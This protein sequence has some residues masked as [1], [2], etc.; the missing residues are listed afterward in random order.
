MCTGNVEIIRRNNSYNINF[1]TYAKNWCTF[2]CLNPFFAPKNCWRISISKIKETCPKC[3][4]KY[5]NAKELQFLSKMQS[6]DFSRRF[7]RNHSLLQKNVGE[8]NATFPS[9]IINIFLSLCVL[10][11]Q[12][13]FLFCESCSITILD[14]FQCYSC[15]RSSSIR[16][17]RL[18]DWRFCMWFYRTKWCNAC[19]MSIVIVALFVKVVICIAFKCTNDNIGI[20]YIFFSLLF[21][22]CLFFFYLVVVVVVAAYH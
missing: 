18:W 11:S 15:A 3:I 1:S 22:S 5:C 16:L 14:S 19:K 6:T 4:S 2:Y 8:Q 13:T 9:M 12:I 10:L 21:C 20:F 17:G 7:Y